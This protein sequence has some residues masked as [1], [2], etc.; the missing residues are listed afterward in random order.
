[1]IEI[2]THGNKLLFWVEAGTFKEEPERDRVLGI[3]TRLR[4]WA[5]DQGA[6]D[7]ICMIVKANAS[8][9]PHLSHLYDNDIPREIIGGGR[10]IVS[11]CGDRMTQPGGYT[12]R[13]NWDAGHS[14]LY[15]LA[16]MSKGG[17]VIVD[18]ENG[19]DGGWINSEG[20]PYLDDT[21]S[22]WDQIVQGV[23]GLNQIC[24]FHGATLITR[25]PMAFHGDSRHFE[26]NVHLLAQWPCPM[27]MVF[28]PGDIRRTIQMMRKPNRRA[29]PSARIEHMIARWEPDDADRFFE[30]GYSMVYIER[31]P[32]G[33]D[34]LDVVDKF[35]GMYGVD[36]A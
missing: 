11:L 27:Q 5:E 34:A 17:Y 33:M 29:V 26:A 1:M 3:A 23:R 30:A 31:E 2:P 4:D 20:E 28:Y 22:D 16:E 9:V 19:Y 13:L 18:L 32:G 35:T 15:E 21:Q 8:T 10:S 6:L 24:K 36:D 14:T 12:D 25:G 7:D